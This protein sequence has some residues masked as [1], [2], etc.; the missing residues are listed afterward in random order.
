MINRQNRF[1]SAKRQKF[2]TGDIVFVEHLNCEAVVLGS[3]RD[4]VET[5]KV[6]DCFGLKLDNGNRSYW[7]HE[8]EMKLIEQL[9]QRNG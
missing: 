7:H 4:L 6:T 9:E 1:G 3:I 8:N 2:R 5:S